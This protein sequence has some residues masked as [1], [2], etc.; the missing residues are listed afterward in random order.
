MA[1]SVKVVSMAALVVVLAFM[2]G[3]E[4]SMGAVYKVGDSTGWT[5]IGSPDYKKWAASKTF[6]VGDTILFVYNA[7]FHNV[8]QVSH[9]EYQSCNVTAPIATHS[10]GNDS[11]VIKKIGHY[12]FFCGVPGHCQSGQKVDIRVLGSTGVAPASAP[13]VSPTGAPASPGSVTGQAPG[14]SPKNSAPVLAYKGLLSFVAMG[15]AIFAGFAY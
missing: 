5:T 12:Y 10:S 8:M 7:Q 11:I 15:L 14:P 2:A 6:H 4:V 1:S 13:G 9:A 3:V